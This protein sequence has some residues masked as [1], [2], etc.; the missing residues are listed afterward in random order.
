MN[1]K[2]DKNVEA[3]RKKKLFPFHR[4]GA[5]ASASALYN[6]KHIC[7]VEGLSNR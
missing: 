4:E 2:K 7:L 3:K 1:E 6:Q 5:T